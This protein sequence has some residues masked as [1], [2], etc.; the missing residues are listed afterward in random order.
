MSRHF[1]RALAALALLASGG[2]S[3]VVGFECREGYSAREGVCVADGDAGPVP[4]RDGST[5]GGDGSV[6][7]GAIPDGA[8]PDGAIPDGGVTDG[9]KLDGDVLD[10]DVLDGGGQDGS[11]PDSSLPDASLPDAGTLVCELGEM[12]CG[13]T[14]VRPDTD[15]T[16]CGGCGVRCAADEVCS[17][18][19]CAPFCTP[20]LVMCGRSC[21]DLT[22]DP[23]NCGRCANRCASGICIDSLCSSGVAGHLVLVGHDFTVGRMGMN[24]IAGNAVF[25]ASGSPVQALVYVEHAAAAS[26]SGT[27]AAIDQVATERGRTWARTMATAVEVPAMLRDADVFIVYSQANATDADLGTLGVEWGAALDGFLR[28][29][30][31]VVVF[32]GAGSNAGTWQ[33]LQ[34][35]G[36]FDATARTDISRTFLNV[37]APIDAT[38]T[39]VPL[40][41]RGEPSTVAFTSLEE[42]VVVR[43]ETL[44]PVVFHQSVVP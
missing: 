28:R 26:V 14:C 36:L 4:G 40:R 37:V 31:V 10:G 27:N 43:D 17:D 7:D 34:A 20:P 12:R 5:G 6:L 32:D 18:G 15:P 38:V 2:C 8:I 23:D 24:R 9:A 22:S 44:A 16:N 39:G 13:E 19:S 29:G 41:Y 21:A 35:A 1:V 25:I 33:V 3:R 42:G 11:L 30:G